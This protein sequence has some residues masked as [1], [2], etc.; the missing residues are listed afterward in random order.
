MLLQERQRGEERGHKVLFLE[1]VRESK[2][3]NLKNANLDRS[4]KTKR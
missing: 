2:P 1:T 3:D 4:G